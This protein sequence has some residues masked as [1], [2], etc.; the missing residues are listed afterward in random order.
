[1]FKRL[2]QILSAFSPAERRAFFVSAIAA[3]VALVLLVGFTIQ[4][5]TEVVPAKGG[6]YAEGFLGQPTHIN[7]VIAGTN[8]DRGL[9]RLLFANLP[10]LAEKIETSENDRTVRVRLKENLAWSDGRE[11]T[12]DD[13]IFTVEK[14]QET[15]TGSPLFSSWQG[16]VASRG[17]KL[18]VIF[19]LSGP[20]QFF[21]ETLDALRVVPKHVFV[22][23]PGAN[24]RLSE[25]NLRPVGSGPYAFLSYEKR[26][27]G[28]ITA[29][30]LAKNNRYAGEQPLLS[31]F[32]AFFYGEE[33]DLIGA[34]DAGQIDGFVSPSAASLDMIARPHEIVA[35]TSPAS[36]AVFWNQSQNLPLQYAEVRKALDLAIDREM[37]VKNF[38]RGEGKPS[39]GP[40]TPGFPGI[41]I[42]TVSMNGNIEEARRL[43]QDDGWK[44]PDGSSIR[45][46][47]IK[48]T[49]LPLSFSLLVPD[50]PLLKEIA[51]SLRASWIALGANVNI[52][53]AS[54]EEI[55]NSAIKNRDYQGILFGNSV[56]RLN[57]LFAFW[58]S[59]ERFY[60]GLNI[61]LYNNKKADQVIESMRNTASIDEQT[62]RAL[63]LYELV[64]SENP[65]IFL[66]SPD[67]LY[68]TGKGVRGISPSFL[69]NISDRFLSVSR[70]HL[71][72][73]RTAKD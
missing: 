49:R 31:A 73:T 38:L 43:L 2:K 15:E 26:P 53:I 11:L 64:R 71:E 17:S 29:F 66:F 12:S 50:V 44:I 46:K 48:K 57:D 68:V 7:P 27:D 63:E 60:P 72:T 9:V 35:F 30:H 54:T 36:Y 21:K 23:I 6:S 14:I 47:T 8:T 67:Y 16:I 4:K 45:E 65:A 24:W 56:L 19:R 33:K 28:F 22:N 13:V 10:S 1:M 20:Y 3:A 51:D 58:H 62:K 69:E 70:W 18:E 40:I 39:F 59:S 55:M 52:V 32:D 37:I 5:Q 25:Y 34:F 41:Q 61:S 42:P